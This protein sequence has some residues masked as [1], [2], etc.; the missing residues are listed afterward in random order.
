MKKILYLILHTN[1][2]SD[3][4][5]HLVDTWLIGKDFIF[6]SDHED[7]EKNVIKVS[8]DD[9]YKSN[10]E[11]FVNVLRNF[12][13]KYLD[14]EWYFFVDNDTFV[15]TKKLESILSELNPEHFYGQK[16]SSWGKD[17][18]LEYLSG[19]AGKLVSNQNLRQMSNS[20]EHKHTTY[21]DVC[22]GLYMRENHK[23]IVNM[24]YFKS[25]PPSF[26]NIELSEVKNYIS[27]HYIKNKEEMIELYKSS[28]L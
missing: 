25:Q 11:K 2:Q 21:A 22:M 4:Y 6:Y 9:T 13:E 8:N 28:I 19:G 16:I 5:N 18:S 1:K 7:L 12:P 3:R 17:K 27:F 14:Y 20:I 15:N 26:Y 23:N 10:E 24:D